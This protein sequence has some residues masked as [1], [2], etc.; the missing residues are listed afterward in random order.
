MLSIDERDDDESTTVL[1]LPYRRNSNA[2]LGYRSMHLPPAPRSVLNG[3]YV[4]YG[5][6]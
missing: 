1:F 5:Y 2:R 3:F 4:N 6:R